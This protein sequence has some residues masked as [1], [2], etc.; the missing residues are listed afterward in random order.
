MNIKITCVFISLFCFTSCSNFVRLTTL[1]QMEVKRYNEKVEYIINSKSD[2]V[3]DSLFEIN[4]ESIKSSDVVILEE[5]IK[6]KEFTP[7]IWFYEFYEFPC[8]LLMLPIGAVA[9]VLDVALLGMMPNKITEGGMNIAFTGM[10]P[11]LNWE[12]DKR[13]VSIINSQDQ[14]IID[15]KHEV[16]RI[17]LHEEKLKIYVGDAIITELITDAKGNCS[18][19]LLDNETIPII[20]DNREMV[21]AVKK[22][23][24][25]FVISYEFKKKIFQYRNII[26]KYEDN[27]GAEQLAQAV[28][29]LEALHMDRIVLQLEKRELERFKGHPDFQIAYRNQL[30]AHMRKS[31]ENKTN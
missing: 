24:K 22:E 7:Y 30:D 8:G 10:N 19:D 5:T 23:L 28:L 12:S 25:T 13:L 9:N 15:K 4:V 6:R 20:L 2:R 26:K 21:V 1:Q 17:P 29:Q 14:K 11:G 3:A 18:L 31:I 16:D 27:P